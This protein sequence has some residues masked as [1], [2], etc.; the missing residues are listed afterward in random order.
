MPTLT[1]ARVVKRYMGYSY[2]I[3]WDKIYRCF[4]VMNQWSDS[5]FNHADNYLLVE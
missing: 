1:R 5:L 2:R 3:Y 4:R